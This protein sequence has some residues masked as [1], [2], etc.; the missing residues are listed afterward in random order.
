MF[1]VK[2]NGT[3]E[4]VSFD[5]ILERIKG[6]CNGIDHVN[7]TLVAQKVCSQIEDGITTTRQD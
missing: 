7:P 6:F 5:K 3:R 4:E 1:V 2:R